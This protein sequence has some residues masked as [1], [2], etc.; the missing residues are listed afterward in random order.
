MRRHW[1]PEG[2]VEHFT[3]SPAESALLAHK[4]GPIR[5]GF[6][7]LLK[8]FQY[9]GHFPASELEVPEAVV[10][11]LAQQVGVRP[12]Q[13]LQYDWNGRTIKSHRA[14]I[15]AALGFRQATVRDAR[16]LAGWLEQHVIPREHRASHL[17]DAASQRLRALRIEPPS[18]D[19]LGRLI[20]SALHTHETRL[21]AQ[22]LARLS[23]TTLAQLD[24]LLNRPGLEAG[25]AT[26]LMR[27]NQSH[28]SLPS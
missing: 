14:Q 17:K 7:V 16:D 28:R 3:L 19:R 4:T 27:W 6:A 23:P 22:V 20:R 24:A 10:A 5:L 21:C 25:N 15:R 18:P 13:Y 9:D 26:P 2:L 11:H 1:P 8:C 12:E